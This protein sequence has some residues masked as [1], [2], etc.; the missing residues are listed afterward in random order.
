MTVKK[1]IKPKTTI[2][3]TVKADVVKVEGWWAKFWAWLT[4]PANA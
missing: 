2:K 1:V 4:G 3:D